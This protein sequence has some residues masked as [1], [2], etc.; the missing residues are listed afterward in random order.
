MNV[1]RIITQEELAEEVCYCRN[2]HSLCV[3]CNSAFASDDWDG[4]YC[5]KCNSTDIGTTTIG[6]WLEEENRKAE[7]K[8]KREWS[9]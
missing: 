6:E 5:G 9:R 1:K 2:C 8:R 4:S 7:A 3:L